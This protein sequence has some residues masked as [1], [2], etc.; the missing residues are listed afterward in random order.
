V[1]V[2]HELRERAVEA[3]DRAAEDDEAGAGEFGGGLEVHAG[4]DGRD[5]EMLE[6]REVEDAG[7]TAAAQ[8][9]IVVLVGAVGD[10]RQRRIRQAEEDVGQAGVVATRVFLEACD[11]VFPRG[12][13][14]AKAVEFGVVAPGAGGADVLRGG[15]AFGQERFGCGDGATP[16][17]VD[18]E[19]LGRDAREPPAAHRG[20]ERLRVLADRLDVM[21]GSRPSGRSRP[22]GGAYFE[23]D[24]ADQSFAR[25]T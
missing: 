4:F 19:N 6:R 24:D 12:H 21:H 1:D 7:R 14:G 13:E 20:V 23:Q 17:L 22:S 25:S 10:F 3:G 16:G 8:F 5:V 2:Q 11:L 9:D 18:G 15:I